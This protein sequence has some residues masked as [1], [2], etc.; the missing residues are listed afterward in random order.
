MIIFAFVGVLVIVGLILFGDDDHL[1][2]PDDP[3]PLP[4]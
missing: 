2:P 4:T 1:D 3:D